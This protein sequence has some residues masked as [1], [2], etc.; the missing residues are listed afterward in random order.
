MAEKVQTL[1][2]DDLD[3]SE[4]DG[5]VRFGLD[6]AEYEIDLNTGQAPATAGGP[7]AVYRC[8]PPRSGEVLRARPAVPARSRRRGPT[9][10]R[11]A[12]GARPRASRSRTAAG[13][14][15]I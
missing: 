15:S 10:L 5:T 14:P 3:S 4:A 7:G 13:Y 9:L 8:R 6:S 1:F 12:S 11:S 2:I